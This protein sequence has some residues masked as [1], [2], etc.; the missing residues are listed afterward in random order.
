MNYRFTE[1]A[2]AA[3]NAAA[4]SASKL[5]HTYIG[6]EHILMGLLYKGTS[7]A[8]NLLAAKGIT[9]EKV[10]EAIGESIGTG[11]PLDGVLPESTPRAARIIEGSAELA[12]MTGQ[13]FIGTEHILM[14]LLKESDSVA[15]RLL[16][17]EGVNAAE[18]YNEALAS[19]EGGERPLGASGGS[20]AHGTK[21]K[22]ASATPT[23]DSYGTDLTALAREGKIDPVIGREEETGRV[24]QI[25]SR[26]TKNNPCLIGE[27]GV[28]KTAVV[29]GLAEKIAEGVVPE[30]V[31]DK[32]VVAL[33]LSGMIAGAK[34]RG[35]FEERIK[36]VMAEIKKAGNVILFIDEIHTI[37]G[38]GSAEGAIDAANILKPALARGEIQVIGATTIDEYRKHIE[39]DAAL[40]R[41]FQSV[42]V[43]EPTAEQA[44]RILKGLRSKYEAHHKIKITDEAIDAA[45]NLSA[46]YITDRFLPDKA[47]DLIDEAASKKRIG[48]ITA[49]PDLR[50]LEEKIKKTHA[51][52]EE[53][54]RAQEFEKAAELRNIENTLSAELETRKNTWKHR[55]DGSH[56]P[57]IGSED[58]AEIVTQW[59]KIPVTKLEKEESEELLNLDKILKERV[60]GQE[61]AVEVVARAIR[62]GRTGLK[63]PK[64]PQGSFIFCGPTGVGKT[65]LSKALAAALFGSESAII[66]VDMSEY[67]E[68]HSVSKLI[69]SPPGYV[70]YDEAGQL[71]EKVRR[72]PYSVVLFDE[73]EKAHPDVFNI[74]LQ[75]L[76]DG[77]LTDSHGRV[78]DFKNTVVILTSNLGASSLAEPKTLGF[79]Q[80]GDSGKRA[81]QKAAE[82]VM[83]ALKK[84]FRPEFLNRIDEI[85][86]FH[87]L[88][89]ENIRKIARLML[90]EI[91]SRIESMKMKITFTDEVVG[92]LAKEGFDPVYGARPLRRAMQRKI[93]DSLSIELLEGKLGAGDVIEAYLDGDVVK[94][95]KTGTFDPEGRE[96]AAVGTSE[97]A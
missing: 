56:M 19:I 8:A 38:A 95:R 21:S 49:P 5:G 1:N 70:G 17:N 81:E 42:M 59:T 3:L 9:Y 13:S 15:V 43:G 18:L 12:R 27:P 63:D 71:T 22:G 45:V 86:I 40:E 41:R 84:A 36:S 78:V 14:A 39:K 50:E 89:D 77:R 67:M 29:E 2:Q 69:G 97:N 44:V 61:E 48:E 90:G 16:K 33:D 52:K 91:T 31:A 62:R 11:E 58:I 46:R 75:I 34:Y 83:E 68:K 93:E 32:R 79:A 47:I 73:I 54:V 10:V 53:A 37:I 72:N 26:R 92:F 74:L 87:K 96:P 66:R 94:Y 23:L 7:I 24:L 4:E 30:T 76:E 64:R 51:D 6:S 88:S 28:G 82:N 57:S 55:T 20:S 60:I 65:E 35:E 80:S 85:V 25:L